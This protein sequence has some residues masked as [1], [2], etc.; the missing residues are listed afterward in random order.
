[1]L[2]SIRGIEY[3]VISNWL[4]SAQQ[5]TERISGNINESIFHQIYSFMHVPEHNNEVNQKIIENSILDL[6]D[7]TLRDKFFV[8]VLRSHNDEIY[9]FS[10]GT[11]NGEYYGARRNETGAIEIMRNNSATGEIPGITR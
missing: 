1:M 10:Y 4:A 2:I 3:L 6:Y 11:S 9:S 5:T 8:G 7:E